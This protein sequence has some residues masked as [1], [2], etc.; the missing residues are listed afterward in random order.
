MSVFPV[1]SAFTVT[2]VMSAFTIHVHQDSVQCQQAGSLGA[3]FSQGGWVVWE[4][5]LVKE[6]GLQS[7]AC[8]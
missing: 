1:M 5:Y 4:L 8:I 2:C 6:H 7:G 3:V